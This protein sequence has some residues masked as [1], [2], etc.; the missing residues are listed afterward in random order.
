MLVV[1]LHVLFDAEADL[2]DVE[3]LG[4]IDVGDGHGDKL[5]TQLHAR[6]LFAA[7]GWQHREDSASR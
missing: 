5:K 3:G 1:D 7:L 6:L 4:A 2:V